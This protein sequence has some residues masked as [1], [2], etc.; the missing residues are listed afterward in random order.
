MTA[1]YSS[2]RYAYEGTET[3][4][5][6]IVRTGGAVDPAGQAQSRKIVTTANTQWLRPFRCEP[7]AVW[8]DTVGADVTVTVYGNGASV[9]AS[10]EVW[11]EV[12]YQSDVSS[13]LG[14][15]VSTS[16]ANVLATGV[17]GTS[18]SSTWAGGTAAFKLVATLS[19]PQPQRPGLIHVRPK[20]G[21]P[22][23]TVY[24]DPQVE[25]TPASTTALMAST[26]KSSRYAYEGTETTE[27]GIVRTGGTAHSRKIV[28]TANAQW[29][30]PYRA[31]PFAIWNATTGADVTVTTFGVVATLPLPLNDELFQEVEYL[32]DSAST[33]GT[34]VTTTKANVLATGVAVASD[35]STWSMINGFEPD[36]A[37]DVTVTN[38]RLTAAQTTTT[39]TSGVHVLTARTTGKYY[40]EMT[41]TVINSGARGVGLI[42]PGA[43]YNGVIATGLN[44]VIYYTNSGNISSNNASSGKSV[45]I[46]AVGQVIGV[47]I[48]LDARKAWFRRAGGNW[49]GEV[50]GISDPAA[51]LGGVTVG[52][53]AFAPVVAFSN[54]FASAFTANFGATAYA[55]AAP[56][57]FSNWDFTLYPFKLTTTLS[58]PQ[59]GQPGLINVRVKAGK[60]SATYYIDPTPELS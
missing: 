35:S 11:L 45:G 59:P 16:K 13:T 48:D 2:S 19:S 58:S 29:L 12:E 57:G 56:S 6:S 20:I 52:S 50:I 40:F 37:I 60:P 38:D 46:A 54:S 5:T 7:Y 22:I 25:L 53:G 47:A 15:I 8:N 14:K 26:H 49:N 10:D 4:E 36:T 44:C 43:S 33:L 17:A 1:P 41:V 27:T 21:K 34:I 30:R 55:N 31:E 42:N 28:T 3:T 9:P 24:L 51:G 32:A 23:A 18:D 39:I